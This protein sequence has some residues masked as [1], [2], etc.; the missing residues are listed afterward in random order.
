MDRSTDQLEFRDKDFDL[1]SPRG[2]KFGGVSSKKRLLTGGV[3]V[4][5]LAVVGLAVALGVVLS[6]GP[7]PKGNVNGASTHGPTAPPAGTALPG[8]ERRYN[9]EVVLTFVRGE[10]ASFSDDLADGASALFVELATYIEREIN[11]IFSEGDLKNVYSDTEVTGFAEDDSGIVAN[12]VLR[13]RSS[14]FPAEITATFRNGLGGAENNLLGTGGYVI[15]PES[16]VIQGEGDVTTTKLQM[17]LTAM[18]GLPAQYT[19]SLGDENSADF[20]KHAVAIEE[21]V[22]ILFQGSDIASTYEG[23]KVVSFR[24]A[25]SGGVLMEIEI[26]QAVDAAVAAVHL[27]NIFETRLGGGLNN[28]LGSEG[29]F[30]D[31][32]SLLAVPSW[33]GDDVVPGPEL[34]CPPGFS[35][36]PLILISLDGF[37][38]DYLLRNVTPYLG[39]LSRYGSHAPYMRAQ[40]PTKTFT[41][42]YTQVTGLYPE[43]HGIV[44]NLM[45]DNVF[46]ATF[47]LSSSEA[48]K[49]RWWGGEPLWNTVEQQGLKAATYFWPGSDVDIQ[50][51]RPS[52]YYDYDGSVSYEDRVDQVLQWLELP[53]NE[54]PS[55][56]ITYFDQPDLAGHING[57][58]SEA[59]YK[60][61]MR[62]DAVIG[63][64]MDGLLARNLSDCVNVVVV[65]DHGMTPTSCDRVV[66]LEDLIDISPLYVSRDGTLMRVTR[67]FYAP[68]S[69]VWDPDGLVKNLTCA[70]DHFTPH[71]KQAGL[72]KRL[73]YANNRRIEDVVCTVQDEWLFARTHSFSRCEGG[74]HGYDNDF[75]NMSALF[76][77]YGPAF[78]QGL[79]VD[80]FG[81]IELYNMFCDL[82][83]VTPAPNN[84]TRGSLNHLLRQPRATPPP[85]EDGLDPAMTC[86]FPSTAS[87]YD[88]IIDA[89]MSGC[90]CNVDQWSTYDQNLNLTDSQ[91]SEY[92]QL[93]LP[94]GTPQNVFT[95]EYC[96]LTTAKYV[97]SFS[98]QYVMPMWTAFTLDQTTQGLSSEIADC[99]RTDVRLPAGQAAS[100]SE[101]QNTSLSTGFLYP[102]GLSADLTGQMDALVMSNVV[103]QYRGF[104]E[105]IWN[106]TMS[107][108]ASWAQTYQGVHVVAGPIF[109]YNFDGVRDNITADYMR[110]VEDTVTGVPTR[111][112]LPTHYFV[113]VTRCDGDN[114][115]TVTCP[116]W[117]VVSFIL[118]HADSTPTCMPMREYLSMHVAR[119]KDVELLTGL[120][121]YRDLPVTEA[122]RLRVHLPETQDLWAWA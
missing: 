85:Q 13:L 5:L 17:T 117:Q 87:D 31:P 38:A 45:Y 116:R 48:K 88:S 6:R 121:F 61:M 78:H 34:S 21:S 3:V 15:L 24:S 71:T 42:H 93:H 27:A 33:L 72:P 92:Q 12:F 90:L 79:V 1:D 30:V 59:V 69:Y 118:P 110:F 97:T 98:Q 67:S 50:G 91:V 76:T 54:R 25:P 18:A 104:K 14:K 16:L 58:D 49:A 100:C 53:Q 55:L 99:L 43:S 32:G 56:L 101:Y 63:R 68:E 64:L 62:V 112:P 19:D 73:H 82:L 36:P 47:R 84:G 70:D 60:E 37:R 39:K 46:R 40:Y 108:A 57:P 23:C 106:F 103:P 113:T 77:A 11:A 95:P 111:I 4:L 2:I 102:P 83:G 86:S 107:L 9:G 114:P 8:R 75:R 51:M 109:D 52:Y 81:N 94:S 7:P 105:G 65:A 120:T 115:P 66:F 29:Y 74:E 35:E 119:V 28:I 10:P 80:P 89:T 22:D 96:V 44:D 41:N 26:Y 20:Q 122:T